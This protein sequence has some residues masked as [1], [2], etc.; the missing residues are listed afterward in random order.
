MDTVTCLNSHILKRAGSSSKYATS[1]ILLFEIT[2]DNILYKNVALQTTPF[3]SCRINATNP[4]TITNNRGRVTPGAFLLQA[5]QWK[6]TFNYPV[7]MDFVPHVTLCPPSGQTGFIS[8]WPHTIGNPTTDL[9]I[10]TSDVT[11]SPQTYSFY[12]TI[13]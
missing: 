2:P 7:G 5:G 9:Y 12:I 10:Y 4:I 1:N 8:A 13:W 11:G 6:L 3:I